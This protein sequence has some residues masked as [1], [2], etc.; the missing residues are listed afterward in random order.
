MNGYYSE[1]QTMLTTGLETGL[2]SATVAGHA[3]DGAADR[4]AAPEG[5]THGAVAPPEGTRLSWVE[6][7][8]WGT[9]HNRVTRL[10]LRDSNTLL[11]GN[12]GTGKST[13]VDAI[14]SLVA[15]HHKITYNQA[16]GAVRD[17]R[18]LRSYALGPYSNTV[19]ELA[20][21]DEAGNGRRRVMYLRSPA[22][23]VSVVL[24]SF[25][26]HRHEA[27]PGTQPE[28]HTIGLVVTFRDGTT[29]QSATPVRTYLLVPGEFTV[30]ENLLGHANLTALRKAI[31][32][33]GGDWWEDSFKT[34]QGAICRALRVTRQGLATFVQAVSMK[35]V[36][37]LT[38]FVRDHMLDHLDMHRDIEAMLAHY[39]DLTGA[40]D[41]VVDARDQ[42]DALDRVMDDAAAYER[43]TGR[44]ATAS[45]V[46]ATIHA[47]VDNIRYEMLTV[48]IAEQ[49]RLLP[50]LRANLNET[51]RQLLGAGQRVLDLRVQIEK[52]GG[53]DLELAKRAVTDAETALNAVLATRRELATLATA[54]GVTAPEDITE[55]G[56]FRAKLTAREKE[57]AADR[58]RLSL[59]EYDRT[60]ALFRARDELK[61]I[62]EGLA[63][64]PA[65]TSNIP[66]EH[67]K[68]RDW[69]ASEAGLDPDDL[70]FAGELLKVTDLAWEPALEMLARPFA[71]QLLVPHDIMA[72]VAAR[73]DTRNLG[74]RLESIDVPNT[75]PVTSPQVRPGTAASKLEVRSGHRFSRWMASEIA[76]RYPHICLTSGA[77]LPQHQRALTVNGQIRDGSRHVKDDRPQ[78]R[79]RLSYAL[80]WDTT[81]RADHLAALLP[82]AKQ[83]LADAKAAADAAD[84]ERKTFDAV[85]YAL[86]QLLERFSDASAIDLPAAQAAHRTAR[87]H[88]DKLAANPALAALNT[89]LESA[90]GEANGL[91]TERSEREQEVWGAENASKVAEAARNLLTVTAIALGPTA[92]Q[93]WDDLEDTVGLAPD[94][95]SGVE[96][97]GRS[98][99]AELDRRMSSARSTL[100][101]NTTN[102]TAAMGQYTSTWGHLL[103]DPDPKNLEY[104]HVLLE[105]RRA[106][107][108]DDLPKWRQQFKELLEKNA[109]QEIAGFNRKLERA[110]ATISDRLKVINKALLTVDYQPG[111]FIQLDP[112]DAADLEVRTFRADLREITAGA[113]ADD[114]D[115]YSEE[116]FLLVRDLLDRFTGRIDAAEKDR[117]WAAKVTDVRNWFAFAATERVHETGAVVDV[118][119]DSGG[120]SGGQKEKLAYTILAASLAYQYGLAGG[121]RDGFRFVMIDE[122]FGKGTEE[123]TRF[124]LEMFGTLGLQLLVATPLA[125]LR[126]IEDYVGAVGYIQLKGQPG[127]ERTSELMSMTITAWRAATH[128][129]ARPG[130]HTQTATAPAGSE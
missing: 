50:E 66:P 93:L 63:K 8:N 52:A 58:G 74:L 10:D 76:R 43:T 81:A 121:D 40:H 73:T 113:L 82:A 28:R 31:R 88:R 2:V 33:A 1:Q 11:T 84:T 120:K 12:V 101:R 6:L 94:D 130:G 45:D 117:K 109:I 108:E 119:E 17:E 24:A 107:E 5:G 75:E 53:A 127:T 20:G 125:K 89:L 78:A 98:L 19:D 61:D 87:N 62:E 80:G 30:K 92:Q 96:T 71:M 85:V 54:A 70:P 103:T 46:A 110:A 91:E 104:R 105:R 60:S 69:L 57:L 42:L 39:E 106:L 59:L 34:Y 122:A 111:T 9:F 44:L 102:L 72:K 23:N 21:T 47:R 14:T 100:E 83:A 32:A 51:K 123:T 3:G 7:Y 38:S 48:I 16:A 41:R 13:L 26:R 22:G 95:V 15:P 25:T 77:D 124:G 126:V 90:E 112:A 18:S 79:S 68:I 49:E 129:P 115:T 35:Q 37:D 65:E 36:G 116:R 97:W 128:L 4:N 86:R 27:L 67:R 99:T 64:A 118:Y 114:A 29:P 55:F 56:M